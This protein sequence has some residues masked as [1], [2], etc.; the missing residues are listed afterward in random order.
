LQ[1]GVLDLTAASRVVL[2]DWN[3]GKFPWYTVSPPSSA[4]SGPSD[5]KFAEMYAKDEVILSTLKSRKEMRK[6]VGVVKFLPGK[7]DNR[8]VDVDAPWTIADGDED[9][10]PDSEDDS[11]ADEEI[12]GD[13]DET[14][15]HDAD[16]ENEDVETEPSLP[17][18]SQKRKRQKGSVLP[19]KRV[20]F[21]P[22]P[23]GSK[24]SRLPSSLKTISKIPKSKPT[25]I[26]Q[27]PTSKPKKVANV[28][29]KTKTSNG[30][31][32]EAYDF[33]QFF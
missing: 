21:A 13:E 26:S 19:N 17:A 7:I 31:G 2:R 15:E 14:S 11:G 4:I 10:N 12:S 29:T 16:E 32:E 3:R 24:Q 20:A 28:V 22:D 9:I 5:A 6:N 33:G 25:K 18:A 8:K 27:P 23:K 1:R 30:N